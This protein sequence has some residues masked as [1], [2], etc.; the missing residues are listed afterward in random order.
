MTGR[1]CQNWKVSLVTNW[2]RN[3]T[4]IKLL[5]SEGILPDLSQLHSRGQAFS[6][7][8]RS[9]QEGKEMIGQEKKKDRKR[10][11]RK[12]KKLVPFPKKKKK[13][14]KNFSF[15]SFSFLHLFSTP[16]PGEPATTAPFSLRHW[17]MIVPHWRIPK[18]N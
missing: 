9:Q 10:K 16:T 5:P 14:K 17:N 2:K 3:S 12:K 1:I 7:H 8:V 4:H 6:L 15:S 13:E 18:T 11:K